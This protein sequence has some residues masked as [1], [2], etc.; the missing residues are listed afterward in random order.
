MICWM[1]QGSRDDFCKCHCYT[2]S[3][4]TCD[5]CLGIRLNCSLPCLHPI[6]ILCYCLDSIVIWL[7]FSLASIAVKIDCL[8]VEV[9]FVAWNGLGA[10]DWYYKID[11]SSFHEILYCCSHDP[12]NDDV[13]YYFV[14]RTCWCMLSLRCA[15][16]VVNALMILMNC[17]HLVPMCDCGQNYHHY[18]H[19]S[20]QQYADLMMM[21]SWNWYAS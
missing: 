7:P 2:V 16:D 13:I 3:E 21:A 18:N 15:F 12:T 5:R 19:S 11:M 14:L 17:V 6:L 4:L 1:M 10:L 9:S 8:P 20:C